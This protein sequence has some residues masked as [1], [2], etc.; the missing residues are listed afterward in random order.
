MKPERSFEAA[1]DD[2]L[3]RSACRA[4]A[5]SAAPEARG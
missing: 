5:C 2:L 4:G 3:T 1:L